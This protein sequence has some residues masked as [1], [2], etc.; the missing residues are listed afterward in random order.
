MGRI[1]GES[2][3]LKNGLADVMYI[4]FSVGRIPSFLSSLLYIVACVTN[5][6]DPTSNILV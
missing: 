4:L 2:Y 5:M 6:V 3:K 1:P